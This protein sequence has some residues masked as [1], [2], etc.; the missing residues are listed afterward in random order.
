MRICCCSIGRRFHAAKIFV[1]L[2][3]VTP[4]SLAAKPA[5]RADEVTPDSGAESV[6]HTVSAPQS[7]PGRRPSVVHA[8][9]TGKPSSWDSRRAVT[10]R[11]S[12][13]TW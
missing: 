2:N 12:G 9:P 5:S 7:R 13:R 6:P 10:P 4:D 1:A 3:E 11:R 8:S